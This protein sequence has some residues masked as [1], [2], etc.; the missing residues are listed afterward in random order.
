MPRV[1]AIE[2]LTLDG[3]YQAPARA[4]EDRRNG[5]SHGGWPN[6]GDDPEMQAIIGHS[7]Q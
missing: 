3:V 1:V 4:D 2:H 7:N 5:F 6:A